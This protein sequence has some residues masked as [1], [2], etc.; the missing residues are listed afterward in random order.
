[1]LGHPEC[2]LDAP[3][4]VV[5]PITN[6]ADCDSTRNDPPRRL[7]HG[8]PFAELIVGGNDNWSPAVSV[9]MT[10]KRCRC[11][12]VGAGRIRPAVR[13]LVGRLHTVQTA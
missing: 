1:M 6:S 8:T 12:A 3:E 9:T 2:L 10:R 4:L 13:L 11:F 7:P 5:G